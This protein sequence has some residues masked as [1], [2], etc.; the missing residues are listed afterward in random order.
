MPPAPPSDIEGHE[1]Y[2]IEGIASLCVYIH[3]AHPNTQF[4]ILMHRPRIASTIEIVFQMYS[5]H[6]LLHGNTADVDFEDG[7]SVL[8]PSKGEDKN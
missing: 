1:C 8:G 2:Y 3:S 6:Y 5:V 4:S 7:N